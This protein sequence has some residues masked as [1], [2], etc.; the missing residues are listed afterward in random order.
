VVLFGIFCAC[1]SDGRT[2]AAPSWNHNG[3]LRLKLRVGS[4]NTKSSEKPFRN[5]T[6]FDFL[7][8]REPKKIAATQD[9]ENVNGA[10]RAFQFWTKSAE[11][12]L[13]YKQMQCTDFIMNTW[14]IHS[15]PEQLNEDIEKRWDQ[16]HEN[17]SDKM[18]KMCLDLG[19]FYLKFGQFL[20]TRHDFM[21]EPFTRKLRALQD[22]V[23]PLPAEE[24]RRVIE[25]ETGC[26]VEET[27]AE[28]DLSQPVGSA[29]ISQ[30]HRGQLRSR[31]CHGKLRDVAVKVQYPGAEAVMIADLANLRKACAYLTRFELNF[32]LA[33]AVRELQAQLA[34]EFDFRREARNMDLIGAS[35]REAFGQKLTVPQSRLVTRRMLV[36]D[37]VVGSPLPQLEAV[38]SSSRRS[39]GFL[40]RRARRRAGE[41]LLA[42]LAHA[43]G[44]MV[45]RCGVFNADPHPGNLL[46]RRAGPASGGL[47]VGL[48]DWGQT[49]ELGEEATAR[50]AHLVKALSQKENK[51]DIVQRF[52]D[53]GMKLENPNDTTSAHA[54]AVT[55]FD[56]RRIPGFVTNPFDS[57]N[58]LRSNAVKV[59][60]PDLFFMLRSIQ[61]IKGISHGL[62]VDFHLSR[63]WAPYADQYLASHGISNISRHTSGAE[64]ELLAATTNGGVASI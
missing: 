51:E 15:K 50:L 45:F 5:N 24:V 59:F 56:T 21:P 63:I 35:L 10:I 58:A 11:I 2:I 31:D 46:L 29:S 1:R 38:F 18:L 54:I 42:R 6:F 47:A 34:H 23:P 52:Y 9:Y 20:S 22:S 60:P 48:L 40:R 43:Y 27:F 53:M 62:D 61:I 32:D 26:P 19:G 4:E 12:Y 57:R 49:K 55:M 8:S 16:L 3:L 64:G 44:H 36:M 37:F 30:V 41:A 17:G 14:P 39:R 25:E 13:S 28:L 33:G 7:K